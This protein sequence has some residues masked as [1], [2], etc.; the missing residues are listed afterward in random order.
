MCYVPAK[1]NIKYT[2]VCRKFVENMATFKAIVRRHQERRDGSFPVS[3]RVIHGR[4]QACIP[5]G[6]YVRK[7]Q[8]NTKTF[9]IKDSFV[10][11]RTN[12][13][14][15]KY[16]QRLLEFDTEEL[17]AMPVDKL[18]QELIG[19]QKDYDYSAFCKKLI[20]QDG[21]KWGALKN[22]LL[23]AEKIGYPHLMLRDIDAS[24]LYKFKK[25]LEEY[26]MPATKRSGETQEKHYSAWSKNHFL[27][28]LG[29]SYKMMRL[30]YRIKDADMDNPFVGLEY[31]KRDAP[32]KGSIDLVT[33]RKFFDY[34]P[35][36][37]LQCMVQDMVKITFCLGGMNLGDL[38]LLTKDCYNEQ[39]HRITYNR[40]KTKNA[41]ADRALT[42]IRVE[43]EIQDLVDKYRALSTDG[44]LF[45]FNDMKFEQCT[46]RNF[47]MSVDR[48]C[49]KAGL[50]HINPYLFRHT[51]A[52]IAR[53]KCGFSRDDVGLLLNHRGVSTVDD[54]YIDDDWSML[55]RI[56]RAVLDYVFKE[57]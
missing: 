48:I 20:E 27:Q 53:N 42:S 37:Q 6:L 35:E 50:P 9:E 32:K 16:E 4:R 54:E 3:I 29:Q 12:L 5:T 55:D 34:K 8:I 36:T 51:V 46:S 41:R 30:E 2:N 39:T 18:V 7:K 47:G 26:T 14:I 10:I 1:S 28:T 40:N 13:T 25:Y 22:A 49:K 57:K 23:I 44:R 45:N 52:T 56:N 43:P 33:L 17:R 21:I 31:Y 11:E 24:F 15:R 19:R 38:L